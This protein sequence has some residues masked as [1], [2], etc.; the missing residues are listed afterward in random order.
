MSITVYY[1]GVSVSSP[2]RKELSI[3]FATHASHELLI[4][5]FLSRLVVRVGYWVVIVTCPDHCQLFY[6]DP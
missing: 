5:Y 6:F 4:F 1:L 2:F 3:Q